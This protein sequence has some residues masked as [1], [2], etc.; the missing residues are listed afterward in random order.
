MLRAVL[1]AAVLALA[2][3]AVADASR[4]PLPPRLT[5]HHAPCPYNPV[6]TLQEDRACSGD[7]DVWISSRADRFDRWHEIG[8]VFDAQVLTDS[9]REYLTRLLGIKPGEWVRDSYRDPSEFFA[10]AYAA[11]ALGLDPDHHWVT[12][13]GYEPTRRQHHAVCNAI[14]FLALAR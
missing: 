13:Y 1:I 10:D 7:E 9:D 3:P 12:G 5:V 8:H 6:G 4:V 11:C 2:A 14:A